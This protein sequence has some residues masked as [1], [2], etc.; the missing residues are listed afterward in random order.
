MAEIP[1]SPSEFFT[2]YV[3]KRFDAIKASLAGKSSSGCISFRVTGVGEWSLRLADGELVVE[4]GVGDDVI[5]Q[6]S[7]NQADFAAVIVEGARQQE[8]KDAKPEQQ[9]MALKAITIDATRA[10]QVRGVAGSV[11]LVVTDGATTRSVTLT[12]GSQ[13][14]NLDAPECKLSCQMSDFIDWQEGRIQPMQLVMTGKMRIE[15]NAQ[16]P[17]ALT[18]V[19]A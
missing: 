12:P 16:I 14:P 1:D 7:V 15:G 3:P 5:M 6:V 9:V 19:L 8:A 4:P 11:G 17:M 13:A 2:Q 18:A 10:A